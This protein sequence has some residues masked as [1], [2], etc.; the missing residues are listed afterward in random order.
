MMGK[1]PGTASSAGRYATQGREIASRYIIPSIDLRAVACKKDPRHSFP[2][3]EILEKPNSLDFSQYDNLT[4][5]QKLGLTVRFGAL[6]LLLI[7]QI[8]CPP[9]GPCQVSWR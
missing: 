4:H 7:S 9:A 6:I 5:L 1:T 2:G 3:T 8:F